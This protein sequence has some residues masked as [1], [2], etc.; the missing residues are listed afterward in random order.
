MKS[1]DG[2]R[3]DSHWR[4]W[5]ATRRRELQQSGLSSDDAATMAH[6]EARGRRRIGRIVGRRA[7]MAANLI[8]IRMADGSLRFFLRGNIEDVPR[9][10]QPLA[11][12]LTEQTVDS[13]AGR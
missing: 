12:E 9:G 4:R 1:W 8:T 10:N 7:A 13:A 3:L 2:N 5:C 11:R 6:R